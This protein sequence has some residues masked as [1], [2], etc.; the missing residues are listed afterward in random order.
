MGP[1]MQIRV[2]TADGLRSSSVAVAWML[3]AYATPVSSAWGRLCYQQYQ[4]CV[5]ATAADDA[6][7]GCCFD[8]N[9]II[10]YQQI[11]ISEMTIQ[12]E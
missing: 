10:I 4:Q 7:G 5:C 3:M 2:S 11:I 9:N 6:G 8:N 1:L 12:V